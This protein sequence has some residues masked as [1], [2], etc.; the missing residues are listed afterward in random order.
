MSK[1]V[2]PTK[3]AALAHV[4]ALIAGTQKHTPNGSF[5]LGNVTYTTASLAGLLQELVAALTALNAAQAGSRDAITALRGVDA[6]VGPVLRAYKRYLLATYGTATQTLADYGLEPAKARTPLT[7][8]AQV[9]AALKAKATRTARGTRGP[10]QK[11]LIK[12]TVE[13]GAG[14]TAAPPAPPAPAIPAK[15]VA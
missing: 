2:K 8:A 14:H 4:T 5:T 15:P 12:G 13:T 1:T 6:K 3:A 7:S 11:A 10:K 9:T